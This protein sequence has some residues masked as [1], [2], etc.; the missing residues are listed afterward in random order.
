MPRTSLALQFFVSRCFILGILLWGN[1]SITL[2]RPLEDFS[3]FHNITHTVYDEHS[4]RPQVSFFY[5]KIEKE[6]KKFKFLRFSLPT[7]VVE[8]LK[9]TFDLSRYDHD[10]VRHRLI[11]FEKKSALRFVRANGVKF[12]FQDPPNKIHTLQAKTVRVSPNGDF[13]L[14]DATWCPYGSK[15]TEFRNLLLSFAPGLT[16]HRLQLDSPRPAKLIIL[17]KNIS[18]KTTGK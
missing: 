4:G 9:I 10:Y 8:D 5:S 2:A 14:E 12:L 18:A 11:E 17:H 15:H 13:K 7:F 1:T 16:G 3:K 6:Y